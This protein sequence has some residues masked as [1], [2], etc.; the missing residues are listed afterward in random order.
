[1]RKLRYPQLDDL[2]I[3][4]RLIIPY[5]EVTDIASLRVGISRLAKRRGIH[6]SVRDDWRNQRVLITRTSGKIEEYKTHVEDVPEHETI[7]NTEDLH[8][9]IEQ[10]R[11]Q[12]NESD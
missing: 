11:K 5:D 3:N 4:Q 6:L 9:R 10:L 7:T 1:M 12:L 8:E 2:N